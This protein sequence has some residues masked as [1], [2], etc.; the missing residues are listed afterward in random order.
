MAKKKNS[1]R[2]ARLN[3]LANSPRFVKLFGV[4]IILLAVLAVGYGAYTLTRDKPSDAASSSDSGIWRYNSNGIKHKGGKLYTKT[5][6]VNLSIEKPQKID[7]T[8]WHADFADLGRYVWYGPAKKLDPGKQYLGCFFYRF[9]NFGS[10]QIEI[11][12]NTGDPGSLLDMLSGNTKGTIWRKYTVNNSLPSTN[13][14]YNRTCLAFYVPKSSTSNKVELRVK[15]GSGRLL[16]KK[17]SITP[18][19]KT[20]NKLKNIYFLKSGKDNKTVVH[21]HGYDAN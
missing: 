18:V 11:S 15:H 6:Y 17:T 21:G 7:K 19:P 3:V 12:N 9:I 8:A 2:L 1:S 16:I 20:K 5:H 10:A 4:L 13:K 14:K